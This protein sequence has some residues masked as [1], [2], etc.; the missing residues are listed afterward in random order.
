[1]ERKAKKVVANLLK[2]SLAIALCAFFAACGS[3]SGSNPAEADL[4][5]QGKSSSSITDD[6]SVEAFED[7]PNCTQKKAGVI[8]DV[9]D[10]EEEYICFEDELVWV[11]VVS[12]LPPECDVDEDEFLYVKKDFYACVDEEWVEYG[13]S[14]DKISDDEEN[15]SSSS[16]DDGSND[17]D[18]GDLIKIGETVIMRDTLV[19]HKTVVVRDTTYVTVVVTK[20]DEK[21]NVV[22]ENQLVP[23]VNAKKAGTLSCNN[24]MF[25]G[26]RGDYRVN[27]GFSD[28]SDTYGYWYTYTDEHNGGNTAFTWP[29]GVDSYGSF[30]Y[31]SVLATAGIKGKVKMGSKYE[32]PYGGL[33]FNLKNESMD[34]VNING[35]DGLCVVYYAS[36]PMYLELHPA[37]EETVTGYNNPKA[38]LPSSLDYGNSNLIADID[39][40][41]FVQAAGWGKEIT[42]SSVLKSTASIAFKFT[43]EPGSTYDFIIFA[44]GK[45][46]TCSTTNIASSSSTSISTVSSSSSEEPTSPFPSVSVTPVSTIDCSDAMYCPQDCRNTSNTTT[47]GK[48]Y[49]GLDDG[50]DT[51]G[52][53]WSYTDVDIGGSTEFYWPEGKDSYGSFET[54]SRD[55]L[56]YLKGAANF[57]SG[58]DYPFARFGFWIKGENK[59]VDITAWGGM[60]LIYSAT[61]DFY[62]I[63]RFADDDDATGSDLIQAKIPKATSKSLVDV[64]WTDFVQEGWGTAVNKS[65]AIANAERIEFSFKGE[66]GTSNNFSIYAI[67]KYGTCD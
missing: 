61:Q 4:K 18:D 28:A 40:N 21:G 53:L 14:D 67:G 37:N 60:C 15:G 6:N 24:A 7:L 52:S 45:K 12:K 9:L 29:E 8:Y 27:T 66:A 19:L 46:G 64:S 55:N 58:Y 65:S 16:K 17:D 48:V 26:G 30:V 63:T 23:M 57:G 43:D 32:F 33:G 34:G 3:E 1:M 38:V 25:C 51:Q 54:N 39:W 2:S 59:S 22:A 31:P 56:G 42:L 11:K 62:I 47:C 5:D 41:Y 50:T 49:T 36:K 13:K 35:W 10:D 20:E 44:I